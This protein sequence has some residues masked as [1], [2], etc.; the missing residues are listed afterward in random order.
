MAVDGL[1]AQSSRNALSCPACGSEVSPNL[2]SCPS[3]QRLVHSGRL[4][5]LAEQADGA[6]RNGDLSSAMAAWRDALS[7]LPAESRQHAVVADRVNRLGR[8][9]EASPSSIAPPASLPN[10]KTPPHAGPSSR[11]SGGAISGII[12][13]LALAVWKFKFAAVLLFSKAKFLLLGLTKASTFLSMFLAVGVYWTVFGGWFALGLV[14]S[15]YVHEM[16]H[17]AMLLRYG[18]RADAPLFIPGL[19]AVIRMRQAFTDP[20]QDARVGLAG[21]I[22]GLGAALV[23]AIVHGVTGEPIWAALAKIGAWV[24]LFNLMP[25][26]Q[27]DGGRAFR[28]LN[29]SQR[30]LATA[31]VATAWAVTEEG[32]LLLLTIA[33]VFRT[34]TDKPGEQP[35]KTILVQY[36]ALVAVLSALTRLSVAVP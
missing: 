23:C 22:W 17:V 12:G 5:E 4:K 11:W 10:D 34:A 28:S 21:P 1:S 25:I 2:L 14:L 16:G 3:C 20:R 19:G 29:R 15:I 13:T 33:G 6:E 27:L 18:V 36:V 26:W 31:A 8:R 35:D 9:V 32:L 24:N 7:L 30:W